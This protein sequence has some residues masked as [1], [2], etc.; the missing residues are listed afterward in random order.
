[1][2]LQ[3]HLVII[4]LLTALTAVGGYVRAPLP[5]VP[6]TLQTLFVYLAGGLLPPGAAALSQ[7]LFLFLGLAGLPIFGLG[8][9]PGYVLQPTFG[10][11]LAFPLAAGLVSR[12]YR[13]QAGR[14]HART[15]ML[16]CGVGMATIFGLGV[17]GLMLNLRFV[18]GTSLA[19][20]KALWSG[21]LLF[22]PAEI[23]KIA[24]AGVLLR[25]L[26]SWGPVHG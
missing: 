19:F 17:L 12:L 23:V 25:R 6:F 15:W 18:A 3:R 26:D 9:G 4:P 22:V 20:T 10:Y 2:T 21:A 7:G 5:P 11:L 24:L 14:W 1:M 8:G 16:A 13:S